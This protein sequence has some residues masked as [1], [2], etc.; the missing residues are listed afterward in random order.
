MPNFVVSSLP[1]Y[2]QDNRDMYLKNFGLIGTATRTRIGVQ[3]GI[4]Y[5][6]HLNYIDIDPT[7]QSGASCGFTPSGAVTLTQREIEVADIKVN[8]DVC[9]KTLVGKYAEYLVRI[10]AN[11]ENLPFEA[12]IMDGLVAEVNKKIEKLIWQGD[13]T[14]TSDT[15]IKWIDGFLTQ[16]AADNDVLTESIALNT[17]V[18]DAIAQVYVAMP[19]YALERGGV[20]FVAPS[21]YRSFLMD[22]VAKNLYHYTGPQDSA[23]EEFTFPGTNLRV[24][25]TP[26]LAATSNILVGTFAANLV[27]G[28]DMENDNEDIKV[29]YDEKEETFGIKL[30]WASGV[31][32]HFPEQI[33]VGTIATS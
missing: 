27:Y 7:L 25:N 12:Y 28:T 20:I 3:T 32:Y 31:A 26:G 24:V 2:V 10:N 15:D 13:K 21:A 6:G 8:L 17:S 1:A 30:N 5:K 9:V 11:A 19:D 14:Q 22:V 4:K 23:P 29:F 16:F 18:Y 33:V